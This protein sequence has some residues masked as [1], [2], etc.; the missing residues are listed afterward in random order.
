MSASS[1]ITVLD[2]DANVVALLDDAR[3]FCLNPVTWMLAAFHV[4]LLFL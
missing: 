3:Q 1:L 4:C 2:V